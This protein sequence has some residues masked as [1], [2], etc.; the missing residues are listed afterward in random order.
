MQCD[1]DLRTAHE[2]GGPA[3][4]KSQ[5]LFNNSEQLH[6]LLVPGFVTASGTVFWKSTILSPGPSPD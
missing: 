3:V 6:R 1:V 5:K 4:A 2:L